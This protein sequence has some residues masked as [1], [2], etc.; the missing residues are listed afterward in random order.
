MLQL[1]KRENHTSEKVYQLHEA[2]LE[3]MK[4]YCENTTKC[5]RNVFINHFNEHSAYER[6]C[7]EEGNIPCDICINL[8]KQKK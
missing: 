7:D 4:E 5:R 1:S 2:S 3:K 8:K 6:L